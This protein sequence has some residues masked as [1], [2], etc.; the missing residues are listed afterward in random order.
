MNARSTDLNP[1]K[2]SCA[3][4]GRLQKRKG[5]GEKEGKTTAE[6]Q[7]SNQPLNLW[8]WKTKR[9]QNTQDPDES[10]TP[11]PSQTQHNLVLLP[12]AQRQHRTVPCC[13]C[14]PRSLAPFSPHH[15]RQR[16]RGMLVPSHHADHIARRVGHHCDHHAHRCIHRCLRRHQGRHRCIAMTMSHVHREGTVC[17]PYH[18]HNLHTT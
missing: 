12:L 9:Y 18:G 15:T 3:A 1:T 10:T 8:Q 7:I 14:I 6:N 11:T 5:E 16:V 13:L 17:R 2:K 4:P